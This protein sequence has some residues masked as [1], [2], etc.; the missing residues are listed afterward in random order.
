MGAPAPQTPRGWELP[1]PK[2]PAGGSGATPPTG[3]V[4]PPGVFLVSLRYSGGQV[5]RRAIYDRSR[6]P[7]PG[8]RQ[9]KIEA[10]ISA[11]VRVDLG[12]DPKGPFEISVK[13]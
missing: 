9:V 12:P 1:L 8:G 4:G 13:P 10:H 7:G 2:P 6:Y 5:I 11:P 3:D